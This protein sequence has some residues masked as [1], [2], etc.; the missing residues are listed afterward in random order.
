MK[1]DTSTF[2]LSHEICCGLDVH[3][4]TVAAC[5]LWT[6]P[7]GKEQ[8]EVREFQT[9]TDDL[10]RLKEWL[11][12]HECPVVAMESTGPYWT[13]IHNILEKCFHVMVVNARHVKNVPGRKTDICDSR[14]L[15]GLLRHG[16]LR[17]GF[18]PPRFQR[19]WRDLTRTR[20]SYNQT[21]GD[22]KR[23]V[24]KLFQQANIKIDS[25]V[26]DLFGLSG[27]NLMKLLLSSDEP[28]TLA[29]VEQCARGS[30][31]EKTKELHRSI[32]GFLERH[33]KDLLAILLETIDD[34]QSKI[35]LLDRRISLVMRD[36][37]D[38]LDRLKQVPGISDISGPAV[39]AE[40]G[41]SLDLFP[42][43]SALASWCGLCPGNNQSAGKRRSGK[44]PMKKNR[45]RTVM[46]EIAW[47]AV[48]TKDSYYK[49]K[50]YALKAR[51]GPKK[52]IIAI[53]HRILK[54]LYHIIKG[55][56][57][58]QELGEDFLLQKNKESRVRNLSKLAAKLGYHLVPVDPPPTTSSKPIFP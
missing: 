5:I 44:N 41:P 1:D 54:A 51:M 43:A 49:A 55:G 28:P 52:A 35:E 48:K 14:W 17:G 53:A 12:E 9:F 50:Y 37:Q 38:L 40:L 31:K 25:V 22:F 56:T 46:V 13:P 27:R 10:M 20:T 34:L 8:S 15:A 30:L 19:Q 16:L 24:H 57:S 39:L 45:L 26:S 42:K 32:Q 7:D 23:R 36:H 33:H 4:K 58:Y 29:E 6:G 18:I 3:K 11:F 47:A 21:A 2:V